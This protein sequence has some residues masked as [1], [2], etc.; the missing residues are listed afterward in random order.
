MK[1]LILAL[2][3]LLSISSCTK[4]STSATENSEILRS[5]K[6]RITAYTYKYELEPGKD[7]VI[8][9]LNKRD[10]CYSDD[11]LTFDSSYNGTQYSEKLK[12]G[13]ELNEMTFNWLLKNNQKTL[14]LSNAQY[15]IGNT[16]KSANSTNGFEYVEAEISKINK[17]SMTINY[18]KTVQVLIQ[19]V[20]TEEGTFEEKTVKFTQTFTK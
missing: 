12:C 11:Y 1:Q 17:K 4:S 18:E 5:G 20:K 9:V 3:V 15:T 8:D 10:T 14:V 16:N 7:T 6:W 13:G 19:P 2:S